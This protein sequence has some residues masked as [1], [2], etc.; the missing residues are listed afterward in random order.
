M[1]DT[2]PTDDVGELEGAPPRYASFILR[3]QT[4]TDGGIRTRLLDVRS[5]FT[6]SVDDLDQ[7]PNIVRELLARRRAHG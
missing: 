5:G 1:K 4:R 7:L 3:C 6:C 2:P